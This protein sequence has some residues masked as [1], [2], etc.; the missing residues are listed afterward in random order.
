MVM[1]NNK[2]KHEEKKMK[3]NKSAKWDSQYDGDQVF[4][5]GH[6]DRWGDMGKVRNY[7]W[8][9]FNNSRMYTEDKPRAENNEGRFVRANFTL[10]L[11]YE[12]T[13][14]RDE[15]KMTWL[16]HIDFPQ[17]FVTK[18][19][20]MEFIDTAHDE[21]QSEGMSIYSDLG[22]LKLKAVKEGK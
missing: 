7:R 15:E 8:S 12:T 2:Q 3:F 13:D 9:Y 21:F 19:D 16:N 5:L 20:M 14:Y 1:I 17:H 18:K 6:Q 10:S 4:Q 22:W 11:D